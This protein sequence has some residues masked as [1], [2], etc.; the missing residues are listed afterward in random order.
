MRYVSL[1]LCLILLCSPMAYGESGLICFT[2]GDSYQVLRE[3]DTGDVMRSRIDACE[4][5]EE[6]C[7]ATLAA[8]KQ[9]SE[10]LQSEAD[11]LKEERDE[12][13]RMIEDAKKAAG[14]AKRGSWWDR[15]KQNSKAAA[16]GAIIGSAVTIYF[17]S[18]N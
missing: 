18:R 16:I 14:V 13:L 6:K 15:I 5:L 12:G 3:L 8:C 17:G 1:A 9:Q 7:E 4:S 11:E 2:K 10:W